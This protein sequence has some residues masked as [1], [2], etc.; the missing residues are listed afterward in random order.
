MTCPK[1]QSLDTIM[2]LSPCL[3]PLLLSLSL[4]YPQSV[5]SE[6]AEDEANNGKHPTPSSGPATLFGLTSQ[7]ALALPTLAGPH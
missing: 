5:A 4:S 2:V 1:S 6:G 7:C 3:L